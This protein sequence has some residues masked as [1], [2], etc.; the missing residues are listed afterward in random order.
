M[1]VLSFV[2]TEIDSGSFTQLMYF[3]DN[4]PVT[5]S[6]VAKFVTGSACIPATGLDK[7]NT[8]KFKHDCLP[9]N[10]SGVCKCLLTVSTFEMI[11]NLPVH[12][13][14]DEEMISVFKDA[15]TWETGFGLV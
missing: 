5:I 10:R 12:I 8:V 1:S 2:E 13:T 11:L 3:S 4:A 15:L 9:K 7:Q 14:K 6:S